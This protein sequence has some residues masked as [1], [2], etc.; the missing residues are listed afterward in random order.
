M[1]RVPLF[2]ELETLTDRECVELLTANHFGRIAFAL[3]GAPMI[4][5]VNYVY[6]EPSVVIRT[7][8][9]TKLAS[10]PQTIVAFEIDDADAAGAWGWSVVIQGPAFDITDSI[11]EYSAAIRKLPVVS[12][13]PGERMHWLKIGAREIS[14]RRFGT[15]PA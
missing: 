8:P 10:T 5:P 15:V 9:G 7:G 6:A 12:Y 13:A 1:S 11:D 14:G 2:E 4:L 3:D